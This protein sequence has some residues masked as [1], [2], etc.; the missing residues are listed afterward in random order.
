MKF[1][2]APSFPSRTTGRIDPLNSSTIIH[3]KPCVNDDVSVLSFDTSYNSVASSSS[4]SSSSSSRFESSRSQVAD[5]TPRRPVRHLPS[6]DSFRR[7]SM[8]ASTSPQALHISSPGRPT[9][10]PGA[11]EL[12]GYIGIVNKLGDKLNELKEQGT[13]S[14]KEIQLQEEIRRLQQ[15]LE[16]ERRVRANVEAKLVL[17]RDISATA[18]AEL[19]LKN[20]MAGMR[21]NIDLIQ[22]HKQTSRARR[23]LMD[24]VGKFDGK[25][26]AKSKRGSDKGRSSRRNSTASNSIC[27]TIP[28]LEPISDLS[29][30]A[31]GSCKSS[32]NR[33][34]QSASTKSR[35]SSRRRRASISS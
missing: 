7:Y 23:A 5:V 1:D 13:D 10:E 32:S 20:V 31:S 26:K 4:S 34:R 6:P 2:T 15:Q 24:V 9:K 14:E 8:P 12:D 28:E 19:E 35:K 29:T 17:E 30:L 16:E 18:K 25:R 33:T 3:V 27:Y 22:D 21:E 11:T